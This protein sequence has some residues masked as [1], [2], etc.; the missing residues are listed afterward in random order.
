MMLT[1]VAATS[2]VIHNYRIMGG[3]GVSPVSP[4]PETG[5]TPVPPGIRCN[6]LESLH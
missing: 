5:G 1:P 6:Q 4:F 2:V 3:T